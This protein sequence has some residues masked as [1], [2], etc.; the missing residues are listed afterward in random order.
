MDL[1]DVH[2]RKSVQTHQ[3]T[4]WMRAQADKTNTLL[5]LIRDGKPMTLRQQLNLAVQLSLPAVIAQLSSIVMQYIDAAMVGHLGA[6]ASASIGLVSTT[7]WLFWGLC[8][9]AAT[10]FSVQVA[11]KIG[12]GDMQGARIVLRQSLTATL[13]FSLL[14]A[15]L[16]A[17]ISGMLPSWLGGDVSIR[18]D[19]SLYFFIFSL[20]LPALQMNFLVGGMLRCSGNM[21]VPSMAGVAMC[22]LDVIFNFFLIFPSREWY[23][24]GSSFTM[25]GAG[26]GVEGA[27]LGTVA[28]EAVV[29]G[30][31]MWYLWT[32][33]DK[34][35]L[36]GEQGSFLLETAI[37]KKALRIGLPMGIEHIV[38]CGA[39]I[40][41]T[42][43][44]APLGVFAIA[45]NSFA[46]TA[47]SLCYMPG[48][49]I[50]DA[51]T[52]LVG[53]SIGAGR[54]K[55]VRSFARITIFMGMT[56]MGLMGILMYL[57]APQIIGLMTPVGEIRELGV[58]ALRIEAFAEPM[59]AASIVAYGVFVGAADTLVPCL[60]NFFSIW[61]VRLSLAALL[62]PSLGLKG[63][64]IAMC[65]EL[66]FRGLIFLVR[67]KQERW[68]R[69]M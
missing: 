31:L 58:M 14:L 4:E 23:V 19:A 32:R 41:T 3:R 5:G 65:I 6:K 37:L 18:R 39:Q 42:V 43:I 25:P 66:C 17:S 49:G 24:L 53:Q 28:A 20:F 57:F 61:A 7:T 34:L 22:V 62:A 60:M 64:W 50:A 1:A 68:M 35:K 13:V 67:L 9:A 46:I 55:L 56:V 69:H 10:G 15:V 44:V 2:L 33:S 63:V 11:H 48:Y 26:L 16:G 21:H 27:A 51:A 40:M 52:T 36:T 8:V 29:T 38:I 47:E 30:I 45:A 54:R 59:F 12:A